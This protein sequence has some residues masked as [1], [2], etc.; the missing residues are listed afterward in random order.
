M[1]TELTL[2]F[3]CAS[4]KAS[5][6]ADGLIWKQALREGT[7]KRNPI[8]TAKGPLVINKRFLDELVASFDDGAWEFV[9]I[10]LSHKDEA[11]KNTGY[12][13]KLKV[14]KDPKRKGKHVLMAGMEFTEP[15]IKEKVLRGSI[16]NVSV[17]VGFNVER[18]EDGKVYPKVLKHLALTNMPW[19][20]G[21]APFGEMAA[22]QNVMI[23]LDELDLEFDADVEINLV[24]PAK[25]KFDETDSFDALRNKIS[26]IVM[27]YKEDYDGTV[28]PWDETM[29]YQGYS[30]LWVSGVNKKTALITCGGGDLGY[31]QR[32]YVANYK[33]GDDGEVSLDA[34]S[35]WMPVQKTWVKLS[36]EFSLEEAA[37]EIDQETAELIESLTEEEIESLMAS[38]EDDDAFDL[39]LSAKTVGPEARQKLRKLLKFY[40]QKPHPFTACVRDNRK[41]FG[42]GTEAVCATLKDIIRGTTKW[43]NGGDHVHAEQDEFDRYVSETDSADAE[44][45]V[46]PIKHD[47]GTAETVD[48][49]EGGETKMEKETKE[50]PKT[51]PE[52]AVATLS[53]EDVDAMVAAKVAEELHAAKE[54]GK[55]EALAE[56]EALEIELSQNRR[57]VHTMH[58][59][60]RIG[61]LN[62]AGYDPAVIKKVQEILLA[63]ERRTEVLTLSREDAEVKLSASDIVNEMLSLFP[64][65]DTA[66]GQPKLSASTEKPQSDNSLEAGNALY[67][68]LFGTQA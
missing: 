25:P 4:G 36:Q 62:A 7:W 43:R 41:R 11:D 23:P 15:D 5:E 57:A 3:F 1:D 50:E 31:E 12:V 17:G 14:V 54:A 67:D 65:K 35:E 2:E 19:I 9:T 33:V 39:E 68:E 60:K 37:P 28:V 61:E 21:L 20:N 32:G 34:P 63:D 56:R 47:V 30:Y 64:A 40:A 10:P 6:D 44:N 42:S 27:N 16:A 55:A 45:A 46:S 66:T 29:G 38:V 58:V 51:E 49:P 53:K 52:P 24:R 13:R 59:E 8:P 18:T 22:A 48:Q 26:S